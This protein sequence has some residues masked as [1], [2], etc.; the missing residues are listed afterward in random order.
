MDHRTLSFGSFEFR[1]VQRVLSEDGRTVPL[2]SRALDVLVLPVGRGKTVAAVSNPSPHW[3]QV[4][5]ARCSLR[6]F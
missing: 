2:C 4:A 6:Q 3:R 1:P 5:F